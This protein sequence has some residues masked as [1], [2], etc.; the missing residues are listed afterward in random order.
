MAIL[1]IQ[2]ISKWEILRLRKQHLA[3][4]CLFAFIAFFLSCSDKEIDPQVREFERLSEEGAFE[5]ANELG[6]EI[7][8]RNIN[9]GR[10]AFVMSDNFLN[11]ELEDSSFHYLNIALEF[12]PEWAELHNNR[13]LIFQHRDEHEA[14][15]LD[16]NRS[17]ELDSTFPY[18]YNNRGYSKML[19]GEF[20][21]G[22]KDVLKSEELDD[23]NAY[24]YRNKA[25]FYEKTGKLANACKWIQQAYGK[26]F[27]DQIESQIEFIELRVCK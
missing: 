8:N 14:A 11:L 13:G 6:R 18:S 26:R 22:M 16:F 4:F 2:D 27:Y 23:N 9:Q 12:E 7:L 10:T 5:A 25:I 15:M 24:V 1:H 17:I 20:K 3:I 21:E 19:M